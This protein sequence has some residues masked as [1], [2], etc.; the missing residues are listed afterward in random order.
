MTR[1]LDVWWEQ[2]VVG[3][4]RLTPDGAM[5][6]AYATEWLAD[7]DRPP[8]SMSLPKRSHRFPARECRPFFAGLLPEE[9]QRDAVA[10]A[11]ALSRHND[12]ALLDALGGD[13]AGALM[14]WPSGKQPPAAGLVPAPVPLG[15]D[16]LFDVLEALPKSPLLAGRREFRLS[17]AGAQPKLPVVLVDGMVALP[18]NG[19]P[20][21][22][23]I[24]P[25]IDRFGALTEN[26]FFVM[27]LA[28]GVG[29][30]VAPVEARTV[31]GRSFLLVTR[32][33][34]RLDDAG[35]ARRVHQEDFCQA[36]G[37]VPEHKYEA[38]G[39]P[40]FAR[41]FDLVRRAAT[42]PAVELL[43]L[44]DAAIFNLIAGNADAHGKN[45]SLLY[46]DGSTRLAPLYD[47]VCT[48][49]YPELSPRMAMK[50][51]KRA[52]LSEMGVKTWPAF[53]EDTGLGAPYVRRRVRELS[54]EVQRKIATV[55]GGVAQ[56]FP[57]GAIDRYTDIIQDRAARVLRTAE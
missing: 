8:I 50:I 29:L 45:F 42:R 54:A 33:D 9:Q 21:T 11:L 34:R 46:D 44:L 35:R 48:A 47:L 20:T 12:F 5:S 25:P 6:F 17:L 56:S 14:L 18:A 40:T 53:A 36:L 7:H 41:S 13:V 37:I 1:S 49:A 55:A 32:Y 52:G 26:E 43:K 10:A 28:A 4:L 38:E 31:K 27:R 22:H 39:G 24:K 51:G 19:Q 23:I 15:N 30:D 57:G 16:A 2:D 3:T